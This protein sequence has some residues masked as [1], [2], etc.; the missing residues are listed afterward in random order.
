MQ[1][2]EML[3]KCVKIVRLHF[4]LVLGFLSHGPVYNTVPFLS[5]CSRA[6]QDLAKNLRACQSVVHSWAW[7]V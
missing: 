2:K 1:G 7:K 3:L 5:L 4:S 6:L